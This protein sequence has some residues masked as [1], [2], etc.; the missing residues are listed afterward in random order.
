MFKNLFSMLLVLMA[1]QGLA[2]T[3][4]LYYNNHAGAGFPNAFSSTR[5]V[6]NWK[7]NANAD[8]S[9]HADFTHAIFQA[10]GG[11]SIDNFWTTTTYAGA[12]DP[13]AG[14]TWL[15]AAWVNWDPQNTNYGAPAV[16]L[17]DGTTFGS[18]SISTVSGT[19]RIAASCTIPAGIYSIPNDILVTDG[20][21]L[22]IAPGAIFRGAGTLVITRGCKLAAEGTAANPIIFTSANTAGNREASDCGGIVLLGRARNN[23]IGNNAPVEGFPAGNDLLTYGYGDAGNTLDDEDNSGTLRYIRIEFGGKVL[24]NNNEIN[25][26]T[27]AAVGSGTTIEYI[28]CSYGADDAF[29]WFGGSVNCKY[30]IA[31]GTYDDEFDTS[32]GYSGKVQFGIGVR[33]PFAIDITNTEARGFE[34]DG[35]ENGFTSTLEYFTNCI[36]SNMTLV[37]PALNGSPDVSTGIGSNTIGAGARIRRNS[38]MRLMNSVVMGYPKLI[39]ITDAATEDNAVNTAGGDSLIVINNNVLIGSTSTVFEA[40]S[41]TSDLA[42]QLAGWYTTGTNVSR[43]AA[44]RFVNTLLLYPNPASSQVQVAFALN[45]AANVRVEILNVSGQVVNVID[46]GTLAAGNHTLRFHTEQLRNG[47][48]F[49]RIYTHGETISARFVVQK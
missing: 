10:S 7:P 25:A 12:V 34:S 26:L 5:A 44:N 21:I 11:S 29:E 48:Y 16:T 36:F 33:D 22:T 4:N 20:A 2:Q 46:Q 18:V 42:N 19:L 6:A 1:T 13:N 38:S 27:M 23:N 49:A 45:S 14:T 37:G 8:V 28:Q 15:D 47:V 9:S 43:E 3:D 31:L 30:L 39:R 40:N 17:Q 35:R 32:F 41:P 24:Q